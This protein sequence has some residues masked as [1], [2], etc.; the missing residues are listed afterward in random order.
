MH[1]VGL[2][3]DNPLQR[4]IKEATIWAQLKHS[5]IQPLLGIT[6]V[7]LGGRTCF[8]LVRKPYLGFDSEC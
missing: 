6:D 3:L 4:Y 1:T 7:T 5:H 8:A 2:T